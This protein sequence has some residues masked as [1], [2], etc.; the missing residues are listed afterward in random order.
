M[1]LMLN[2]YAFGQPTTNAADPT[3]AAANVFSI[4]GDYYATNIATNYNPF[5]GQSPRGKSRKQLD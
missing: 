5:W 4:Y 2:F 1:G 3:C